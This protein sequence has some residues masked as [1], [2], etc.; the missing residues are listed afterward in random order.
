VWDELRALSPMH[1]GMS[2]E[3][4]EK[5]GGI[6]WPCPD[7]THPGELFLHARLWEDDPAKRGA[8]AP[9][10]P[11]EQDPPVDELSEEFPIRLTTGR[12]LD[13]FNT[14]VQTGHYTTPLRRPETLNLAPEDALRLRLAE[15]EVARASSRRGSLEVPVHIDHDLRPGLAFMT[16]HFPEQ[17]QTNVLTL[18]AWDP[19]SG[20]A[21]FKATAIRVDKLNA[22]GPSG[23]QSEHV[24]AGA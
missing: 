5:L 17:V 19:K 2:Y 15:G 20:T 24:K 9:F 1:G 10:T 14:G 11:V 12:R 16:L 13:S 3:R 18:D 4:L 8:P 6:Q 7:E 22:A 21:E 23:A